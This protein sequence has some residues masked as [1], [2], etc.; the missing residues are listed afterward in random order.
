MSLDPGQFKNFVSSV[1]LEIPNGFSDSALIAALMCAAHESH[2]GK[3][4]K[5]RNGPALGPYQ[6]EPATHDD[7]WRHGQSC[8]KNAQLLGIEHDTDRLAYDLRY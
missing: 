5:Q 4:L 1:L 3:Y 8:C 2:L 7:T 6:V